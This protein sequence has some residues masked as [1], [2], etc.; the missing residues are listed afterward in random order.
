MTKELLSEMCT[1]V[2]SPLPPVDWNEIGEEVWGDAVGYH[3]AHL[4][5]DPAH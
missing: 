4:A 3:Q 2:R 5:F 1:H